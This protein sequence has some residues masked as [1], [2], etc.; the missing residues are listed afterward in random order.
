MLRLAAA[1]GSTVAHSTNDPAVVAGAATMTLE[2]L[3]REPMLDALVVAVGGGSQAVGA[4]TVA[5]SLRPPLG[6]YGVQA[7][8]ACAIHG[9]RHARAPRPTERPATLGEGRTTAP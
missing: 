1:R 6:V 9:S 4:L 3:E 8:G 5:R 7:A 2:I